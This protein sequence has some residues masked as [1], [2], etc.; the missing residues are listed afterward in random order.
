MEVTHINYL[1]D[2]DEISIKNPEG[3]T[4]HFKASTDP[5]KLARMLM[6]YCS[7]RHPV[8]MSPTFITYVQAFLSEEVIKA[9]LT[10]NKLKFDYYES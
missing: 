2:S 10:F 9:I 3:W 6:H 8:E 5:G 1:V 7:F 4:K